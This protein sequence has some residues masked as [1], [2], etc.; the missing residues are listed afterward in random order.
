MIDMEGTP[1]PEPGTGLMLA[2]G[3]LG[4]VTLRRLKDGAAAVAPFERNRSARVLSAFW[5]PCAVP[6]SSHRRQTSK[7]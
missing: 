1:V 5:V 7:G 6:I 2:F 4:L 3:A